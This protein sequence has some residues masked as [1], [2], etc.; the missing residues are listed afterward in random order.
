MK[1][2]GILV[3]AG[4]QTIFDTTKGVETKA[5]AGKIQNTHWRK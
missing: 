2:A 1:D 5:V 3:K 4:M